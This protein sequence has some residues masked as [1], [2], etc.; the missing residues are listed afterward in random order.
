MSSSQSS[1]KEVAVDDFGGKVLRPLSESEEGGY[2]S[3]RMSIFDL[4]AFTNPT[5]RESVREIVSSTSVSL[6]ELVSLRLGEERPFSGGPR[7]AI[8]KATG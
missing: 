5:P 1:S 8:A 2:E 6:L 4:A 3:F 7:G